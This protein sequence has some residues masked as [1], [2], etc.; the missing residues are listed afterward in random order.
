MLCNIALLEEGINS[1]IRLLLLKTVNDLTEYHIKI[2]NNLGISNRKLLECLQKY[3]E[4]GV[5]G[6]LKFVV[7]I[8]DELSKFIHYIC[9]HGEEVV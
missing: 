3:G 4:K 5:E 6:N 2:T 9:K 8:V 7:K 1:E